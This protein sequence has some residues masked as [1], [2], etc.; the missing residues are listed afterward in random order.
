M[1]TGASSELTN[2]PSVTEARE[3]LSES[4]QYEVVQHRDEYQ[5]IMFSIPYHI[6]PYSL[7][8]YKVNNEGLI[9][10]F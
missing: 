5:K 8:G 10:C 2:S 9:L 7:K 6:L 4:S 3:A 1:T